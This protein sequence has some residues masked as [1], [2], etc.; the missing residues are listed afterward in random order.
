MGAVF[1]IVAALVAYI[2]GK[3]LHVRQEGLTFRLD[4]PWTRHH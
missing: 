3:L 4:L 2:L 1:S